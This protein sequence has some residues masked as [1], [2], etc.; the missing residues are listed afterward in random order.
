M[1]IYTFSTDGTT[2]G[3]TTRRPRTSRDLA[4]GEWV[5]L[6][7]NSGTADY[8]RCGWYAITEVPRPDDDHVKSISDAPFT[9]VWTFDQ[10]LADANAAAATAAA[11]GV[12]VVQAVAVLRQWAADAAGTN[13]TNGNNTN[14]TQ[15]VVDRLGVFFDRFADL[16][17]SD[18][19]N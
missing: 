5:M 7:A 19:L 11:N 16:I 3:P 18:K 17:E 4:T 9:E 12:N 14:V 13:V 8:E 6:N 10:A 2:P 15:T 1:T